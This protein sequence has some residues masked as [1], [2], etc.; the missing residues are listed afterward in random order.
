MTCRGAEER[1]NN[2]ARILALKRVLWS[3]EASVTVTPCVARKKPICR[4]GTST[5]QKWGLPERASSHKP[6]RYFSQ[7]R[8]IWNKHK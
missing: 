4:R 1:I 6:P 3:P 8:F 7:A 5:S 2:L